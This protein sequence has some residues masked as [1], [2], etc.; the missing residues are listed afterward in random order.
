MSFSSIEVHPNSPHQVDFFEL[1]IPQEILAILIWFLLCIWTKSC[2]F[3]FIDIFLE[4]H[5]IFVG[6]SDL[7]KRLGD[8]S[9]FRLV[10]WLIQ[11]LGF[12]VS[13]FDECEMRCCQVVHPPLWFLVSSS[14][15]L[16]YKISWPSWV[17][18]STLQGFE[19]SYS[20]DFQWPGDVVVKIGL[21]YERHCAVVPTL[22][23]ILKLTLR[24]LK[25]PLKNIAS[26]QRWTP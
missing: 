20:V 22:C 14:L 23:K 5:W 16:T 8:S 21:R 7:N 2:L 11:E 6:T 17:L 15:Y 25:I 3:K 10:Q 13:N 12:G 18:T 1:E 24:E 19:A 4:I 9:W 26:F